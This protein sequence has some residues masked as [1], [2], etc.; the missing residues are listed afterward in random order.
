MYNNTFRFIDILQDMVK[1][2][3]ATPHAALLNRAPD[4][5]T[6]ENLYPIW[7]SYYLSHA[8]KQTQIKFRFQP[9]ER[10]RISRLKS[11]L[12]KAYR[13]TYSEEIFTVL[14]RRHTRPPSYVLTDIR[15]SVVQGV[16]Y[17]PEMIRV[18][19]RESQTYVIRDVI[20]RFTDP[21]TGKRMATVTWEGWPKSH[22]S[23]IPED[24]IRETSRQASAESDGEEDVPHSPFAP[25]SSDQVQR[26]VPRRRAT[27]APAATPAPPA[28]TSTDYTPR[29]TSSGMTLRPRRGR[30]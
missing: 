19:D 11:A 30:Q 10:V 16:F 28:T 27:P 22:R 21:K 13:G 26:P 6:Q 5:V 3:N 25:L 23:T 12:D 24:S 18:N 7:E 29:V 4:S 17:E 2:L 1:S 9:G 8:P 20:R 15:G 14:S